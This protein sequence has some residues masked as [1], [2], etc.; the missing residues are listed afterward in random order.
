M[1]NEAKPEASEESLRK[2]LEKNPEKFQ[3]KGKSRMVSLKEPS[4]IKKGWADPRTQFVYKFMKFILVYGFFLNVVV[5]VIFNI[6]F[7]IS[8]WVKY[9]I[10][11]GI[12]YYFIKRELPEI[13]KGL[14]R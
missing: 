1:A 14:K 12:L 5:F 4:K 7:T 8:T 10:A 13:V 11:L 9:W 3:R 6:Q 2:Q